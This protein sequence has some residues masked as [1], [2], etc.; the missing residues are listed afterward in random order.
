MAI[1]TTDESFPNISPTDEEQT[2]IV[3]LANSDTL[4]EDLVDS[5]APHIAGYETEKLALA[6]QLFGGV[7]KELSDG[8]RVRGDIHT[9]FVTDPGTLIDQLLESAGNCSPRTVQVAGNEVTGP[10]LTAAAVAADDTLGRGPWTMEAGALVEADGGHAI[11][12]DVDALDDQAAGGLQT[13]LRNQTVDASKASETVSLSARTAVMGQAKPEY[14]RFDA[15]EPVGGQLNVSPAL[16]N[17]FDLIF[18]I[19]QTLDESEAAKRTEQMLEA[20]YK[21]ELTEH[22]AETRVSA[23]TE[24]DIAEVADQVDPAIDH[25]LLRKYVVFARRNCFPA[26]TDAAKSAI[27]TYY[28]DLHTRDA[29]DVPVGVGDQMLELLVRLAEASARA[30]LSDSVDEEDVNRAIDIVQYY[31]E[32]LGLPSG[33]DTV[34]A[35]VVETDPSRLERD[36]S[37][38]VLA[39]ISDLEPKHD[40]GAPV[41]I[42]IDEAVESGMKSSKA[43]HEIEQLKQQGEIYTPTKGHLRTT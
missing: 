5:I 30:R 41:E 21:S 14:G 32:G 42:V 29:E 7:T 22:V 18:V 25:S 36:P 24:E 13:V 1:E 9:L 11:I 43:E 23:Y 35:E 8:T 2:E 10:G 12:T 37:D 16:V 33:T 40:K 20:H 17:A 39:L 26:L 34:D 28:T 27:N 3:E 19:D 31:L 38:Q 15:Y 4:F 6:L